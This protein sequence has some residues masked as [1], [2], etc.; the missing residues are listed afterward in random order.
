MQQK[1]A[2]D[3]NEDA[4]K[5]A[6]CQDKLGSVRGGVCAFEPGVPHAHGQYE[7]AIK[8]ATCQIS[9]HTTMSVGLR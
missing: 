9:E 1:R 6:K 7:R 3:S 5:A 2:F 4:S 8:S